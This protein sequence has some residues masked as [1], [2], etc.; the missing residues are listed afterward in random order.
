MQSQKNEVKEALFTSPH[1]RCYRC[2]GEMVLSVKAGTFIPVIWACGC[3][4]AMIVGTKK[5]EA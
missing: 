4:A 5:G 2:A 3:G 1:L